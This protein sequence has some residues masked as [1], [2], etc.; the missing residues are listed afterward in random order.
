MRTPFLTLCFL[1][2]LL[3]AG[4]GMTRAQDYT[5]K[6]NYDNT[7]TITRYIGT[8]AW[9][10][11]GKKLKN[12]SRR[13]PNG[14]VRSEVCA[15]LRKNGNEDSTGAL[16]NMVAQEYRIPRDC[17]WREMRWPGTVKSEEPDRL[18]YE[19]MGYLLEV[20]K[21][22]KNAECIELRFREGSSGDFRYFLAH[23]LY[24]LGR[25]PELDPARDRPLQQ[26]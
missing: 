12:I 22:E 19:C 15:E 17:R 18:L 9:A 20:G 25:K 16:L 8:N 26:Q 6:T 21:I 7:I 2:A 5:C 11:P 1:M 24:K 23:V 14:V 10:R 4:V 13:D 3:V